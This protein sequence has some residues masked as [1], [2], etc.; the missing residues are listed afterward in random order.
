MVGIDEDIADIIYK[1]AA[2]KLCLNASIQA[3]V[4]LIVQGLFIPLI[5]QHIICSDGPRI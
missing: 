5:M 2:S 4:S 1:Y 3:T